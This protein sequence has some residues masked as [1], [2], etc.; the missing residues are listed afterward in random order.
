MAMLAKKSLHFV[1][2]FNFDEKIHIMPIREITHLISN[3]TWNTS[4]FM[5]YI[6][7]YSYN[8]FLSIVMNIYSIC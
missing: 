8:L 2:I 3:I 1:F 7:L 5:E 4:Y 6:L